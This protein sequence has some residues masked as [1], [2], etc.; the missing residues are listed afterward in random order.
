MS[1]KA[2]LIF[3][4]FVLSCTGF[5]ARALAYTYTE[6]IVPGLTGA[7]ASGIN[8]HGDIV[9][10]GTGSNGVTGFLD[11]GGAFTLLS[12]PGSISTK[13]ASIN[14]AGDIVGTYTDSD[15]SHGFKYSGGAWTSIDAP[16]PALPNTT[17]LTAINNIG[18]IAGN[19]TTRFPGSTLTATDGFVDTAGTFS[20]VPVFP[21]DF[22][23]INGL[24]DSSE[25]A[26]IDGGPPPAPAYG[27]VAAF[28]RTLMISGG[29]F[30]VAEG[31]FTAINDGGQVIFVLNAVS[32]LQSSPMQSTPGTPIFFQGANQTTALGI[33]NSGNVVGYFVDS[34]GQNHAFVAVIPSAPTCS[35]DVQP[36]EM[37]FSLQASL[38]LAQAGPIANTLNVSSFATGYTQGQTSPWLLGSTAID[39]RH[40]AISGGTITDESGNTSTCTSRVPG[41]GA[42]WSG[43]GGVLTTSVGVAATSSSCTRDQPGCE[44]AFD[45]FGPGSDSL[46][47][48]ITQTAPVGPWGPWAGFGS[49]AFAG[50]PAVGRTYNFGLLEVLVVGSDGWLWYT[51]QTAPG[52][53][54][55]SPWIRLVPGVKG[56]P[57]LIRNLHGELQAFVRGT[58][59]SVIFVTQSY[60][61]S[62]FW[63]VSSLG[64]IITSDPAAALDSS[65]TSVV[66]ALGTDHALWAS[67][68]AGDGTTLLPWQSL[69]GSLQGTP[70]LVARAGFLNVF[71][72][73]TDN[74]VWFNWQTGSMGHTWDGGWQ[75]LG[76]EIVNNPRAIEN[77]DGRL[78]VFVAGTD[79]AVWHAAQ[80]T[81]AGGVPWAPWSTLGGI[82]IGDVVPAVDAS[83][84]VNIF[85]LGSDSSLWY[86]TQPLPGFWY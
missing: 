27:T 42:Q 45:V 38:G 48:H 43:L 47:F 40:V 52:S 35:T 14:D 23:T 54:D 74:S 19:A 13:A 9:G 53:W 24:N 12:F 44:G 29:G 78:E 79:N 30:P 18:Q 5:S 6:I 85:V 46:L 70:S 58:D 86:L 31:Y 20:F 33:N 17:F 16:S 32:Y 57:A 71:A 7:T 22:F 62:N 10:W 41:T 77:S 4:L 67:G 37:V 8:I 36:Q 69:G 60:P 75:S 84:S 26:G 81:G 82:I 11:S 49:T 15:G 72:R 68:V 59:D 28:S 76:G 64:G 66:V 25:I 51:S 39:P 56:H 73:G 50:E 65:G 83:G 34:A 55:G 3:A 21:N 1:R 63:G 80:I 61:G 2:L